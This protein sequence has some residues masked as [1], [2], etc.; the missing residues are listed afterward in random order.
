M[1]VGSPVQVRARA[2]WGAR[3]WA[4][5]LVVVVVVVVVGG[6]YFGECAS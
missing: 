5:L 3:L 2:V 4:R 6:S 1:N